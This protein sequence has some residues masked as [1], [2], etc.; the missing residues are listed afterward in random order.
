MKKSWQDMLS[1]DV[2]Q[3]F[4]NCTTHKNDLP[5]LVNARWKMYQESGKDKL[6]FTK[7]DALVEMLDWLDSNS[8]WFDLTKEEYNS[9]KQ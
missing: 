8:C 4:C 7:E 6:G 2:Y 9:L 5:E 1:P 3:R